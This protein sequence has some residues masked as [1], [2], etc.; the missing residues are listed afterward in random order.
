[1]NRTCA[2]FLAQVLPI[3]MSIKIRKVD[4]GE[5]EAPCMVKEWD[6]SNLNHGWWEDHCMSL[7]HFMKQMYC[8]IQN[9]LPPPCDC[10]Q[11]RGILPHQRPVVTY[12][13]TRILP[14]ISSVVDL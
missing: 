8:M 4:E 9:Y 6:K 13:H 3:C 10:D 2:F 14:P 12:D 1:M 7:I 5:W 11:F